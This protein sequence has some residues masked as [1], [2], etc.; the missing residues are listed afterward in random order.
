[1]EDRE[2]KVTEAWTSENS[3]S[4]AS[5]KFNRNGKVST[6][7]FNKASSNQEEFTQFPFGFLIS[8]NFDTD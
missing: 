4:H 1:M 8:N 3:S 7:H 2:A 5:A 6:T